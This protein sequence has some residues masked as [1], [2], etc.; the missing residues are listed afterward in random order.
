MPKSCTEGDAEA[1]W[2][3]SIVAELEDSCHVAGTARELILKPC[4]KVRW[5]SVTSS[6]VF[7]HEHPD[8]HMYFEPYLVLSA[9]THTVAGILRPSSTPYSARALRM[10]LTTACNASNCWTAPLSTAPALE[11]QGATIS[12][13]PAEFENKIKEQKE[14]V[15]LDTIGRHHLSLSQ[16]W[17][18]L[19]GAQLFEKCIK[20][21][22]CVLMGYHK[23]IRRANSCACALLLLVN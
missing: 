12:A 22:S 8:F 11:G 19:N 10:D 21:R 2:H 17:T 7:F 6:H 14:Q 4:T 9:A 1:S 20:S 23:S 5:A 3:C 16:P 18:S 15:Q 13:S